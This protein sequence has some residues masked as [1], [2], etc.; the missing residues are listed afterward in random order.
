MNQDSLRQQVMFLNMN[1][2][3]YKEMAQ[4]LGV[5]QSS[6][7]SWVSGNYDFKEEVADRLQEC[8]VDVL[9]EKTPKGKQNKTVR[10]LINLFQDY[11]FQ[12]NEILKGLPQYDS[13][14]RYYITN[15]GNVFSL[16]GNDWIKKKPQVDSDGYLYVDIW[17]NGERT[18]KRIHTLVIEAF[19]PSI[20]LN[21]I[22]IHHLDQD[23]QNN[24]LE[25][26]IP[27]TREQHC[28]IHKY[29]QKWGVEIEGIQSNLSTIQAKSE[30]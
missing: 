25:N 21:G 1:K 10:N 9:L 20:D 24:Q 16:C 22:E 18:R 17:C 19:M 23:K 8:I 15:Y 26:L 14:E 13:N 5:N 2:V 28:K 4:V 7:Y 6:F 30:S 27:L 12:E 3:S 11:T 29:L